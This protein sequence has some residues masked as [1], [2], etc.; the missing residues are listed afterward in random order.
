[1]E[2]II[3][4]LEILKLLRDIKDIR[5]N[6][7][8]YHWNLQYRNIK[9]HN[10]KLDTEQLY[11]DYISSKNLEIFCIKRKI[12]ILRNRLKLESDICLS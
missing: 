7:N 8:D 5:G 10:G 4:R 6:F 2:K 3:I 11:N 9:Y 12:V 1:M